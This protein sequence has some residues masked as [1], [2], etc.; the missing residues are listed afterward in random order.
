MVLMAL[1]KYIANSRLPIIQ[2]GTDQGLCFVPERS[3]VINIEQ[4]RYES[5]LEYVHLHSSLSAEV[6][7]SDIFVRYVFRKP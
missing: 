4:L 3:S 5:N 7:T 1:D 6:T 2:M